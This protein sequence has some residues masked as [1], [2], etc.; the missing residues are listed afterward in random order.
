MKK[1]VNILYILLLLILY[2]IAILL[3]T[4]IAIAFFLLA[5]ISTPLGGLIMYIKEI[6]DER[7]KNV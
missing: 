6:R 4:P 3:F 5:I 2:V 7:I 1:L